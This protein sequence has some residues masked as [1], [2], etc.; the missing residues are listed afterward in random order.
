MFTNFFQF[1]VA[2]SRRELSFTKWFNVEKIRDQLQ[3]DLKSVAMYHSVH[4][5]ECIPDWRRSYIAHLFQVVPGTW[6]VFS[7]I[8]RQY[9]TNKKCDFDLDL[10][11]VCLMY[12]QILRSNYH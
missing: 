11:N 5:S 1:N 4:N 2:F 6:E 9:T 10:Y 7:N 8:K 3:K 12:H